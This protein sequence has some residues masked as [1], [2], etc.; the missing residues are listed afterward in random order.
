MRLTA[1]TIKALKL[2]KGV[3]D[4]VFFDERLPGFGLRLRAS[5]AKSYLVQYAIAGKSRRLTI[6]TPAHLDPNAAF[7]AAKDLLAR[8]RL[9]FDPVAE[10]DQ[11]RSRASET[12]GAVLPLFMERQRAKQ[13]PRGFQETVRH[14]EV[15]AKPL[16]P[17]PVAAIDRRMVANL[18]LEIA[19]KRGPGASNRCRAA[20]SCFASW[21]VKRGLAPHNEAAYTD[22]AIEGGARDRVLTDDELRAIWTA[23]PDDTYGRVI[24]LLML[25]GCRRDEI[26]AL[27]WSE[28]DLKSALISLPPERTKNS[29]PHIVPLSPPALAILAAQPRTGD[30]VF[31]GTK[32]GFQNW[33]RHKDA[34]D[35][36]ITE[37]EAKPLAPWRLH[38]FRRSLSTWLHENG[39][40][41]HVVESLLGHVGLYKSGVSAT[42]NLAEYR[43]ERTRWLTRWGEH[44]TGLPAR[45]V[46]PRRA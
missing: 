35:E 15:Y 37:R 45:K 43:G 38:D 36:R 7:D 18:L 39:A 44:V 12:M 10:R 1:S 34:L 28:A 33:S 42:Y 40:A 46:V 21:A 14:L 17:Y 9:G 2:P 22:K 30:L 25:T 41:P 31:S 32:G 29:R 8:V 3:K 23:L 27:Q 16:H 26:G 6:G 24:R 5:G 20:L 13:K 19:D 4:F 11:S